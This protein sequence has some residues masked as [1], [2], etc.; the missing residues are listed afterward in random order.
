MS[1]T[2]FKASSGDQP[3]TIQLANLKSGF[4]VFLIALPLCLGIASASECPPIAGIYT[5]IFGGLLATF[6]SNSQLT[7]KGPAAGLIVIVMGCVLQ[8]H[9]LILDSGLASP[10]TAKFEAYRMALAVCVVAG[11]LQI[12]F[13]LVKGGILGDFF[14][15]SAVH[16][17]LASIG[18]IIM[19][20]QLPVALGVPA[21]FLKDSHKH[22]LE[23]LALILKMPS[24]ITHFNPYVALLGIVGLTIMFGIPLIYPRIT[25]LV[26]SQLIV[27]LVTVPLATFVLGIPGA[28]QPEVSK[29]F[30]GESYK[31]ASNQL[32][33]VPSTAVSDLAGRAG[34]LLHFQFL[35]NFAALKY[36]LAWK[37]IALFAII[38]SL[39]S[40]LS[41][42]AV[43]MLDPLRRKTDLN[44]DLLAVGVA[45]TVAAFFGGI[46]MI[47]EIVRSRANIDNG[48]KTRTAN[49]YHGLFLLA[50]VALIPAL[51]NRIP[52]AALA[53]ML[54]FTGFRLAHP[55]EFLH[56]LHIGREQ[57]IVFVSTI[58]GVLAT[59]LLIG[60]FIGMSV[61]VLIHFMHG[62]P[63]LSLFRPFLT[64]DAVDERTYRIA[65]SKSAVFS[66]W[67]LFRRQICTYGLVEHKNIIV[68]LSDTQLVDHTVM[69]KLH[70]LQDDF[71]AQELSLEIVGLESHMSISSHPNSARVRGLQSS[72]TH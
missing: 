51:L 7:I 49:L 48:A 60:I 69:E 38:G 45:N 67:L 63:L 62:V 70:E 1:D 3:F 19:A 33:N 68:D 8:F 12:V 21:E 71:A 16:G 64:I 32:V 6:L 14:P 31:L 23:P 54:I 24:I 57:L 44:R 22:P 34:S 15:S 41:S 55:R 29:Q 46:P 26:P 27:L 72:T 61:K 18:V 10:E 58:V 5:A 50:S 39:E 17:L 47:S 37:W 43:D 2:A 65:A 35:P 28:G 40:L 25:K 53:S 52:L 36:G 59:D 4:M 9:E 13:G 42:K 30:L 11:V 66:N 56:V 20:K